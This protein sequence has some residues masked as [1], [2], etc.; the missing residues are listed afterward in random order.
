MQTSRYDTSGRWYK[1]NVHLHSTASD[2][3]RTFAEIA[4]MYAGAGYHFLF[5]TDHWVASDVAADPAEYPLLWLDGIELDGEDHGGSRYHVVCLGK[6]AGLS[7]DMGL[8]AAMEA[9]RAQGAFLVLAHP[10]WMGNSQDD[11]TRYG[12]DAVE[13]YNHVCRWLNGK[14]DAFVYWQMMLDR[15]PETLGLAVDDAHIRPEHPG[16]NG[17]WIMINAPALSPESVR[18]ALRAGNYYSSCGPEFS[19]IECDGTQVTVETS[20]VQFARLVG[21]GWSGQREGSFEGSLLAAAT[22]EI[23]PNWAY[24]YL[25][26]EDAQGRRAWTNPLLRKNSDDTASK[27]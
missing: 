16:W 12:F 6:V 24:A 15:F 8:V 23:P 1:G 19:T 4:A 26:I 27:A 10:T 17:G 14:G 20:P 22:F 7:R 13:A 21:P 11:A 2:G 25:E 5:R 3:G 18:A 9:A